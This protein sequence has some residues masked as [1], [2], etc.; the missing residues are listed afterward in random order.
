MKDP[1]AAI[2]VMRTPARR[3][4]PSIADYCRDKHGDGENANL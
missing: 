4:R 2:A 3:T 1:N